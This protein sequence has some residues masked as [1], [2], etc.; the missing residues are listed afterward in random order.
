MK[1]FIICLWVIK[2]VCRILCCNLLNPK[3]CNQTR[4]WSFPSCAFYL[5]RYNIQIHIVC[6]LIY[7][8]QKLNLFIFLAF[9]Y[10]HHAGTHLSGCVHGLCSGRYH[11]DMSRLCFNRVL[12]SICCCADRET[13]PQWRNMKRSWNL[14]G[15]ILH[16]PLP[17]DGWVAPWI[18]V[19]DVFVRW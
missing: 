2:S 7:V 18:L 6:C 17:M 19:R 11:L 12:V 8:Q 16:F 1:P 3:Q 15:S 5:I 4:K 13:G 9:P 14:A 10:Y